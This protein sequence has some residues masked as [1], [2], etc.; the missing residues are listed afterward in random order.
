ML[1]N[2]I[3]PV[4]VVLF[5]AVL[6]LIIAY[7]TV[8]DLNI[9]IRTTALLSAFVGVVFGVAGVV[10]FKIAKTTVNPHKIENASQL[11]TSG[12]FKFTR[13]PMYVGLAFLLVGWGL[14]LSSLLSFVGVIGFMIYITYFQIKPEEKMLIKLFGDEYLNYMSRVRRW[15]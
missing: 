8:I 11:V 13:N 10:S 1:H 2:K 5:F 6:M 12:I 9:F 4:I 14:W 15:L 7:Y 3:P